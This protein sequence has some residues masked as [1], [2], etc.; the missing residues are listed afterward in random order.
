M[1]DSTMS[2]S[3]QNSNLFDKAA[4]LSQTIRV[5]G[6]ADEEQK[7][8]T[9]KQRKHL[10]KS[11][12]TNF[13]F[14]GGAQDRPTEV[15]PIVLPSKRTLN[16]KLSKKELERKHEILRENGWQNSIAVNVGTF[17]Q[18]QSNG[19]STQIPVLNKSKL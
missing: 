9:V 16:R 3:P 17:T 11:V 10:S 7:D 19:N 8:K 14:T 6:E 12:L 5:E 18:Q 2:V 1:N 13:Y 15:P 4:I